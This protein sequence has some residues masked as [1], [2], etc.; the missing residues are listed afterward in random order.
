MLIMRQMEKQAAKLQRALWQRAERFKLYKSGKLWLVSG[1]VS[2]FV[3]AGVMLSP[4]VQ[5]V[6]ASTATAG[7]TTEETSGITNT[8]VAHSSADVKASVASTSSATVVNTGNDSSTATS[9]TSTASASTSVS[10]VAS[11][12]NGSAESLAATSAA[13]AATTSVAVDDSSAALPASSAATAGAE[14]SS[15]TSGSSAA[16]AQT[17]TSVAH[18]ALRTRSLASSAAPADSEVTTAIN[19]GAANAP[20]TVSYHNGSTQPTISVMVS[21]NFQAGDVVT[22]Y[23]DTTAMSVTAATTVKGATESNV[24]VSTNDGRTVKGAQY[25]FSSDYNG[26]FPVVFVL[27]GTADDQ[28]NNGTSTATIAV[29]VDKNGTIVATNSVVLDKSYTMTQPNDTIRRNILNGTN[30]VTAGVIAQGAVTS[31]LTLRA[32]LQ[33]LQYFG[34]YSTLVNSSPYEKLTAASTVTF[35]FSDQLKVDSAVLSDDAVATGVTLTRSGNSVTLTLPSGLTLAAISKLAGYLQVGL[36]PVTVPTTS[37][38]YVLPTLT[39]TWTIDGQ[40]NTVTEPGNSGSSHANEFAYNIQTYTAV[41]TVTVSSSSSYLGLLQQ[42]TDND[43]GLQWVVA[44]ESNFA[45]GTTTTGSLSITSSPDNSVGITSVN[46]LDGNYLT[47]AGLSKNL[48]ITFTT[49]DGQSQSFEYVDGTTSYVATV[50]SATDPVTQVQIVDHAAQTAPYVTGS[51]SHLQ[52]GLIAYGDEKTTVTATADT[53]LYDGDGKLVLDTASSTDSD[54]V[55]E[56]TVTKTYYPQPSIVLSAGSNGVD[57]QQGNT[58]QQIYNPGDE[59]TESVNLLD[60]GTN[61][62]SASDQVGRIGNGDGKQPAVEAVAAQ[63]PMTIVVVAPTNTDFADDATLLSTLNKSDI[64][65][66]GDLEITHLDDVDGRPVIAITGVDHY[67]ASSRLPIVLQVNADAIGGSTISALNTIYVMPSAVL[68]QYN[69][70]TILTSDGSLATD[71][72]TGN[73]YNLST[74]GSQLGTIITASSFTANASITGSAD[75]SAQVQTGTINVD[76]DQATGK[77]TLYNGTTNPVTDT[78]TTVNLVDADGNQY[79]TLTGPVQVVDDAGN[80]VA[81][82]VTYYQNGAVVTDPTQADSFTVSGVSLAKKGSYAVI[83]YGL[84]VVPSQLA[85]AL[86]NKTWAYQTSTQGYTAGTV[87]TGNLVPLGAAI[88]NTLVLQ[89]IR[90]L[91][92]TWYVAQ[93]KADGTYVVDSAVAAVTTTGVV[94]RIYNGYT[95]MG[96]SAADVGQAYGDDGAVLVGVYDATTGQMVADGSMITY[97]EQVN[98][99]GTITGHTYYLVTEQDVATKLN[100]VTVTYNGQTA[101]SEVAGLQATANKVNVGLTSDDITVVKDGINAGTYT[102][103]LNAQGLAKLQAAVG[104]DAIVTDVGVTGTITIQPAVTTVT[105]NPGALTYDGRTPASGASLTATVAGQTLK[106][107][108]GDV[109]VADDGIDVGT[110]TYQLTAAGL[111]SYKVRLVVTT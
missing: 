96:T 27:N 71:W 40:T 103:Q 81:A 108:S 68:S 93:R 62:G 11:A 17:V 106:L 79:I 67:T 3:G 32:Q 109:T 14:T 35:D 82:A 65:S 34:D 80:T 52:V 41:G 39:A 1:I 18:Q 58:A 9:A 51:I 37:T 84:T 100:D 53:S 75:S 91:T 26:A 99:D 23:L 49:A 33:G 85:G 46:G 44:N 57:N 76:D 50:G 4:Q 45:S 92:D 97:A 6:A 13:T 104:N 83:S 29:D 10:A 105:L 54:V 16:S 56:R 98:S 95:L 24:D 28:I 107:N 47:S 36:L 110:Y 74:G 12:T 73:M 88:S 77:T 111:S 59:L 42:G 78:L 48:T 86:T 87:A 19:S 61:S 64:S 31:E 90:D 69:N 22:V 72:A 101:A 15:A 5:N 66:S 89:A 102:Y 20:A 38:R 55:R 21:G 30:G 94:G 70:G 7:S 43:Y 25:Q 2:L 8:S 60:G 63:N